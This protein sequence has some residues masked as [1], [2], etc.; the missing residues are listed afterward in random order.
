MHRA[1]HSG[2]T[3]INSWA[4]LIT[5][6]SGYHST[7]LSSAILNLNKFCL[8]ISNQQN[9]STGKHD[10]LYSSLTAQIKIAIPLSIL[11]F[12]LMAVSSKVSC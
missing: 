9:R 6:L 12:Q 4:I 5:L 11:L 3:P 1:E 8:S 10:E 7:S 2:F